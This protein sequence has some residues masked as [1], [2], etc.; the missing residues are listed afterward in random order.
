MGGTLFIAADSQLLQDARKH[1]GSTAIEH[2]AAAILVYRHPSG[3]TGLDVDSSSEALVYSLL[4]DAH[5]IS[6]TGDV[7]SF[8]GVSDSFEADVLSFLSKGGPN[9]VT[10]VGLG[11]EI[12]KVLDEFADYSAVLRRNELRSRY[13]KQRVEVPAAMLSQLFEQD[14]KGYFEAL[15]MVYQRCERVMIWPS[16]GD[17]LGMHVV[18]LS[19]DSGRRLG[20]IVEEWARDHRCKIIHD[21]SREELPAW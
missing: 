13:G 12:Q 14:R 8:S 10:F 15:Q 16:Y 20:E 21:T 3:R 19:H 4:A 7:A 9:P 18:C 11:S 5:V 1:L 6:P 17:G 2:N